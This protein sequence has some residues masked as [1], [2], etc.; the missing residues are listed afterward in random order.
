M[1]ERAGRKP[2]PNVTEIFLEMSHSA[3]SLHTILSSSFLLFISPVSPPVLTCKVKSFLIQLQ[4][5]L[6]PSLLL[7]SP[8][9][10]TPWKHSARLPEG[11]S[12]PLILC[13]C[14]ALSWAGSSLLLHSPPG[15]LVIQ[16]SAQVS[17]LPFTIK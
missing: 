2:G 13:L 15:Q 9:S 6:H 14:L 17:P 8:L 4:P 16:L 5:H 11:L 3:T 1:N 12:Q 7:H 10:R